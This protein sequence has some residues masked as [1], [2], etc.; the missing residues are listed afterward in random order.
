MVLKW[1]AAPE[2]PV[3]TEKDLHLWRARLDLPANTLAELS[4][5][6]SA[7]EQE[8]VARLRLRN[9]LVARRFTAGRAILR[10]IL[11]RYLG[12]EPSQVRFA[13]SNG[14]KPFLAASSEQNRLYFNLSHSHNLA[15]FVITGSYEAGVDL[16]YLRQ[17]LDIN[18]IAHNFFLSPEIESL[19]SQAATER[20]ETFFHFWTVKEAYW[21][22]CG[23]NLASPVKP[24]T[25]FNPENFNPVETSSEI[26]RFRLYSFLPEPDYLGALAV[27]NNFQGQVSCWNW[28]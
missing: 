17:E 27:S 18:Q 2:S 14:K 16:E 4:Q 5:A 13:Y 8:R 6:L 25:R 21:K 10:Q 24:L 28:P 26:S 7:E 11:G 1:E 19:N 15:L 20:R 22:A 23:Q 3:I 9:P 12:L